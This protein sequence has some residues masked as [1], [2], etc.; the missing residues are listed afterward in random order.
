MD[1]LKKNERNAA[2]KGKIFSHKIHLFTANL[3][4]IE[5]AV[6]TFDTLHFTLEHDII[7]MFF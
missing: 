5:I 2:L 1:K 4:Q 6:Q 3:K 7:V